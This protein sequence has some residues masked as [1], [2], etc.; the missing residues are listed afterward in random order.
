[1]TLCT[2]IPRSCNA[3]AGEQIAIHGCFCHHLG[4]IASLQK[5]VRCFK[6]YGSHLQVHCARATTVKLAEGFS[7]QS[8]KQKSGPGVS[9]SY[10]IRNVTSQLCVE[11]EE[12]SWIVV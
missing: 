12:R 1:M 4:L 6:H 10:S 11:A 5:S 2:G 3:K 9:C 7:S 8:P